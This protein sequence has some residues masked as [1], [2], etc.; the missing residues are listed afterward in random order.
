MLQERSI[1]PDP[2]GSNLGVQN[3]GRWIGSEPTRSSALYKRFITRFPSF[4]QLASLSSLLAVRILPEN[5]NPSS[6]N[7][8]QKHMDRGL[9]P[10]SYCSKH[11]SVTEIH[12]HPLNQRGS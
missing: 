6:H 9:I 11:E 7:T 8:T 10:S 5:P 2:S 3:T 1:D 12:M 4:F